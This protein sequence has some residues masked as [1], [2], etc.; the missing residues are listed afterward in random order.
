VNQYSGISAGGVSFADEK[1]TQ[2]QPA[3][4]ALL[5]VSKVLQRDFQTLQTDQKQF[6]N[7]GLRPISL[8]SVGFSLSQPTSLPLKDA[9]LWFRP[10]G[11]VALKVDINVRKSSNGKD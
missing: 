10:K 11:K 8:A 4:L 6:L 5:G 3:K 9:D 1:N 7:S 2:Q